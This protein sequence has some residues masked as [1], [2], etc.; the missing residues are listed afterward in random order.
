MNLLRRD[1]VCERLRL[2]RRASYRIVSPSRLSL[3]SSDEI[4]YILNHAR[5]GPVDYLH[6]IPSDLRTPEEM[7]AKLGGVTAKMLLNWTHRTKNVAPH[8]RLNKQ[9]TRFSE[10]LLLAW[11]ESCTHRRTA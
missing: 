3:I 6:D 1:L 7:A 2:N 5:R 8:F 10:R 4:L 11:L 9:T